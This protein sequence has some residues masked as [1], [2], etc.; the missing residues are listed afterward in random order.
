MRSS[1]AVRLVHG[2]EWGAGNV[3]LFAIGGRLYRVAATGGALVRLLENDTA[4]GWPQFLPGGMRFLYTSL[5]SRAASPRERVLN[6]GELDPGTASTSARVMPL[7][8]TA[9]YAEPGYLVFAR[10]GVLLAQRFNSGTASLSGVPVPIAPRV[11]VSDANFRSADFAV[12]GDGAVV[13][14]TG[15]NRSRL[16]WM[17]GRASN[18]ARS[19]NRT[20][21]LNQSS[22]PMALRSLSRS[23]KGTD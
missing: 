12:G 1:T 21:M 23:M 22:H 18:A 7:E 10:D 20:I 15:S 2:G 6:I 19:V 13:Y 8:Y 17:G 4:I 11:G 14:R 16:T 5:E 9:Q 3:I